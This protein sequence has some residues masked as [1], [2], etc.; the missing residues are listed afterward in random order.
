MFYIVGGS[1]A[2]VPAA[3]AA[4][5]IA[6]TGLI[7]WIVFAVGIGAIILGGLLP[8][9]IGAHFGFNLPMFLADLPDDD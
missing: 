3:L 4:G 5:G 8:P 9:K 2:A 1:I 7:E 6:I